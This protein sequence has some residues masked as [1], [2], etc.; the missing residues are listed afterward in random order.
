MLHEWLVANGFT[1]G[2]AYS[3][4][5]LVVVLVAMVLRGR[6]T[7]DASTP[8]GGDAV[9][10][11]LAT[12]ALVLL[13]R[14]LVRDHI[15]GDFI[16]QDEAIDACIKPLQQRLGL[17]IWAGFSKTI[18]ST[19]N[20]LALETLGFSPRVLRTL[21]AV[22]FSVG[23]GLFTAL[24]LRVLGTWPV[25]A[26]AALLAASYP[27]ILHSVWAT[28]IPWGA[29]PTLALWAILLSP[30]AI[31]VSLAGLIGILTGSSLYFYPGATLAML[32]AV[33]LHGLL[34][35]AR[36]SLGSAAT[37]VVTTV[38]AKSVL[39]LVYG[40]GLRTGYGGGTLSAAYL[41]EALRVTP[42]DFFHHSTSYDVLNFGGPVF[43]PVM[44]W[45]LVLACCAPTRVLVLGLGTFVAN[46]VAT[47]FTGPYPG[48]R[49]ALWSLP[50]LYLAC[51]DGTL[52]LATRR[53]VSRLV[54]T[55]LVAS[56]ALVCARS[57]VIGWT[58]FPVYPHHPFMREVFRVLGE[59]PATRRIVFLEDTTDLR[60]HDA[61][62]AVAFARAAHGAGT[63]PILWPKD[64]PFVGPAGEYWLFLRPADTD[65]EVDAVFGAASR[66]AV[67][68]A[69]GA[70]ADATPPLRV[71]RV[72]IP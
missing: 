65:A 68:V 42:A 8:G 60:G 69:A 49:R 9:A 53:R 39:D 11:G 61:W 34:Y 58:R 4:A 55:L 25:L 67:S 41:G 12:F 21:P 22:W 35:R 16:Y 44:L 26:T 72:T 36:W 20:G 48:A 29:L 52:R 56:I 62:C 23:L 10:W 40:A 66:E 47:G 24:L 15:L 3:V 38:G 7:G 27:F 13:S 33:A 71:A 19:I 1:L 17:P 50:L 14:V 6:E 63:P 51:I 45:T 37:A 54:E 70:A 46:V 2:A 5:V 32:C 28:I 57:A 30:W 59:W 18:V 64:E 43:E 31:G